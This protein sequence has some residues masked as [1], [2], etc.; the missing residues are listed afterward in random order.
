M[1]EYI[2]LPT[3]TLSILIIGLTMAH[4]INV[5]PELPRDRDRNTRRFAGRGGPA[6]PSTAASL[7]GKDE[8][9]GY[10][11]TP[12]EIVELRTTLVRAKK[13]PVDIVD[14]IFN[15]AEYWACNSNE[16]DFMKEHSAP[17]RINGR[18]RTEDK[19]LV[20]PFTRIS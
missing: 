5:H 3:V 17:A 7:T 13:L 20:S 12:L 11:P 15:H 18:S 4:M 19:F 1:F 6:P 2:D 16:I 8:H 14:E 10:I 9:G